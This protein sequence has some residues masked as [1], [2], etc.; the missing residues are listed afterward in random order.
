MREIQGDAKN[1]RNLLG[2]GAK[3][4][5]DYYQREYRWESKQVT[6]LIEDLAEKFHESYKE[7]DARSGVQD[8]G[9]YFLGSIIISE[10]DGKRF[11]IDGQQR[12][13]SLTLL[14]IYLHRELEDHQQQ[15]QISD[16]IFSLSFGERSFNL[17]VPERKACMNALFTGETLERKDQPES[18]INILDRFQDIEK[19]FPDDLKDNALPYFVDWLIE[20]V[21]L[22]EITASSDADAYTIFETMNDRGLSLT[23]TEMLKSYLLANIQE[24]E[25]RN[26][27]SETWRGRVESLQKFG[28][29]T[30]ANALTAWLRSQYAE[31]IRER[32]R[33]AK[34]RDF[35][36]I[37]TEFHRWIRDHAS[38]LSLMES[39]DFRRFIQDD[40]VFYSR[41]YERI[42]E[43]AH[44][45]TDGLECIY[46]NEQ[47]NFTLQ[48][49]MLLAPIQTID[50][51]PHI[52]CKLR[53]V[54]AYIDSLVAR[55]I[56]NW[57]STA[58]STMQYAMFL[59]IKEIRGKSVE[60]LAGILY[61][62][63]HEEGLAFG[64]NGFAMHRRN[65]RQIHRMLARMT[66]Y[67]ATGSGQQPKYMEYTDWRISDPYQVEHIWAD[68]PER[69]TSEFSHP[70]DFASYRNRIGGLLLLPRSFNAAFGDK[71]YIEKYEPYFGQNP[72]AQSL[73]AKAYENNPG[74]R[75]F[76]AES[77]LPFKAHPQFNRD[78]LDERQEL[79]RRIAEQIWD[80]ETLQREADTLSH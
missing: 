27:A 47:N 45:L 12:I 44:R 10:R 57:R 66:D 22:V 33:G 9:R 69:H 37:G 38:E 28:R 4:A 58:Y 67:V 52:I 31:T 30:E 21:R 54:A 56:W 20:N 50:P 8:Y 35:G 32:R 63:L 46:Y 77:G 48:Y 74:F 80:A 25:S 70:N 79:Y 17:E 14:L 59:V 13:T 55:R 65:G 68:H 51:E 42:R 76:C 26:E 16:L 73:N 60:E 43:A 34:P 36:L 19:A 62:R 7:G 78:D 29:G 72:L 71:L 39:C 11:I 2:G 1:V 75:R 5:I 3:F 64:D 61:R 18:V 41:W 15:G 24:A 6:E 53:I 49:P 23:P 40:F